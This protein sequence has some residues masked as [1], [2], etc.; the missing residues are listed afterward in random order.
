MFKNLLID[1]LESKIPH[2]V[3]EAERTI[4][5]LDQNTYVD[6]SN[7]IRWKSNNSVPPV[8]CLELYVYI[9][10][11]HFDYQL[12]LKTRESEESA[13]LE[14]YRE[15]ESKRVISEEEMYELKASFGEGTTIVNVITGKEIK[16]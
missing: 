9:G 12:S 2:K 1:G 4:E 14:N 11:T 7:V 5:M 16:L 10:K 3:K 8:D 15:Q 13:F 6:D